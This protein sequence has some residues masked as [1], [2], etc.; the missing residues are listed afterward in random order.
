M[1]R[2]LIFPGSFQSVKNYGGYRGVDIWL[3]ST[4]AGEIPPAACYIGHSGGASFVLSRYDS[5]RPGKLIFVNP[6]VKKRR[7]AVLIWDWLIFLA[8]EGVRMDKIVPVMDWPHGIKMLWRVLPIDT[9]AVMQKIP[10]EDIIVVRG[11]HDHYFCDDESAAMIRDAGIK[12]VEVDAGHDWNGTIARA[13]EN[14]LAD[15]R[16]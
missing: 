1:E 11:R 2:A 9:W 13:V 15:I 6:F 3:R 8:F 7:I 14:C 5:L 12:L 4:P 10:K 16:I